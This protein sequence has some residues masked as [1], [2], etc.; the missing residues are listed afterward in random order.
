[1]LNRKYNHVNTSLLFKKKRV[2][3]VYTLKHFL[4]FTQ[5]DVIEKNVV[6]VRLWQD[7]LFFTMNGERSRRPFSFPSRLLLYM[8]G[9]GVFII[10]F[11][12]SL[13]RCV[14]SVWTQTLVQTLGRVFFFFS[15]GSSSCIAWAIW[16]AMKRVECKMPHQQ[17]THT[18]RERDAQAHNTREI[19]LFF[20]SF[21]FSFGV[22]TAG[23]GEDQKK[24]SLPPPENKNFFLRGEYTHTHIYKSRKNN[25]NNSSR[26]RS[27][28]T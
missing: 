26:G 21:L 16:G 27:R 25:N 15:W 7:K 24:Q 19:F 17:H 14:S 9:L 5:C 10:L 6:T 20:S 23:Q 2:V 12:L 4:A 18:E 22:K 8:A 28:I 1:M 13:W 11:S 3:C